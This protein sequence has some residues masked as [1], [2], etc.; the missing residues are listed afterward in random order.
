ML[1]VMQMQMQRIGGRPFS[2]VCVYVTTLKVNADRNPNV[3]SEQTLSRYEPVGDQ[4]TREPSPDV[5]PRGSLSSVSVVEAP[6]NM[7]PGYQ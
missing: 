7:Y 6:L 3:L 2:C 5:R 1:M 4:G